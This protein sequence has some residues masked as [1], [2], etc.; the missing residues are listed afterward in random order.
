MF[1]EFRK[2]TISLNY[3]YD[4]CVPGYGGY[5]ATLAGLAGGADAA[6]I[7]EEPQSID[8]LVEDVKHLSSK[9][10]SG[11]ITRGLV[12]R[13]RQNPHRQRRPWNRIQIF[14]SFQERMRERELQH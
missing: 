11:K 7:F 3:K 8:Q 9:I 13:Y 12:L 10:A 1:S 6:Y 2:T 14:F 4:L 5:L